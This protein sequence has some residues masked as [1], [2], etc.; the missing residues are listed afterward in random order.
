MRCEFICRPQTADQVQSDSGY[1][2]R[3][4][5]DSRETVRWRIQVFTHTQ[6]Q[7]TPR[8][9]L[10]TLF[11]ETG[12][13]PIMYR[14]MLLS[15]RYLTYLS[16]LPG[17][18]YAASALKDSIALSQQGAPSWFND[19][20][21]VLLLFPR[22]HRTEALTALLPYAQSTEE[23][24]KGLTVEVLSTCEAY[25]Q[26]ALDSSPKT[27]LLLGRLEKDEKGVF[28]QKTVA[29]RHYLHVLVPAHRVS[30]T[31]LLLSDHCLAEEQ[32]RRE[33]RYRRAYPRPKRLCRF[34]CEEVE[35]PLHAL[36]TCARNGDLAALRADFLHV[37]E[38]SST[39]VQH[40]LHSGSALEL[41]RA[42]YAEKKLAN[43]FARFTHKTLSLFASFP[44]RI[45]D[46]NAVYI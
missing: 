6:L 25:L 22:T 29:F 14:R 9:M 36:F 45:P 4:T 19:L 23:Q 15:L 34:G 44:I 37:V 10:A 8:S 7:N 11:T 28:K 46:D 5:N 38:E 16:R 13:V 12:M 31:R 41:F 30:L 20:R 18:S 40:A 39:T 26:S 3:A 21:R 27:E 43:L 35:S 32:L 24:L 2:T 33:T 42:V 1:S 17:S